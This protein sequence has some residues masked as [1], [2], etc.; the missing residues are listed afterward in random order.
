VQYLLL[1]LN[2]HKKFNFLVRDYTTEPLTNTLKT[3][4]QIS[5]RFRKY[6]NRKTG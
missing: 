1:L 3:D 2:L 4:Q 6:Q 5:L